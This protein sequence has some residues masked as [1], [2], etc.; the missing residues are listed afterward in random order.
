MALVGALS[1]ARFERVRELGRG[2]FGAV[3]LVRDRE[4]DGAF[5]LKVI[6]LLSAR[7][8][9]AAHAEVRILESC[10]HPNVIAYFG[11]FVEGGALHIVLEFCDAGDLAA[12]VCSAR[13]AGAPLAEQ[14]LLSIF[15]QLS[16]AL[17]YVHSRGLI[18]RD[19]KSANVF[20]LRG[21]GDGGG[22]LTVKLADFGISRVLGDRSLA[23]TVIGTP[24][25]MSPELVN[26]EPCVRRLRC[27]RAPRRRRTTL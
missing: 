8:A 7:E 27:H 3:F 11:S 12:L 14:H 13:D 9:A 10:A 26:G 5:A 19:V 23:S 17:F 6:T 20:L 22:E 1:N 16:S 15:A 4:T 18:H 25:N 24:Y 2:A 21:S